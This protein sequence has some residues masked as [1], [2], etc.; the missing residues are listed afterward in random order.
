MEQKSKHPSFE[1]CCEAD[2]HKLRDMSALLE[3][4]QRQVWINV[5]VLDLHQFV[6]D[7]LRL[8]HSWQE[9]FLDSLVRAAERK[10]K[11]CVR[12]EKLTK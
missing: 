6:T 7:H 4:Q 10:N 1:Q 12:K 8:L 3:K 5:F 11:V 2:I 9:V